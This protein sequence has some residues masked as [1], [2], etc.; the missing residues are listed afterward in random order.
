MSVPLGVVLLSDGGEVTDLQEAK[1]EGFQSS[2][3]TI[4]SN[5]WGPPDDGF[6]VE[7][8]A[9]LLQSVLQTNTQKVG[10]HF[11]ECSNLLFSTDP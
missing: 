11:S 9:S 1:A 4:Y 6:Y 10:R 2:Y 5:S 8:P 7:G 3:V